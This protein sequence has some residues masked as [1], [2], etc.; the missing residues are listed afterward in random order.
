GYS[1]VQEFD[2]KEQLEI[3]K[4][5]RGFLRMYTFLIQATAYQNEVLHERYNYIQA[6][7]KEID[8]TL[9]GTDFTIADK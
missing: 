9:G 2:E 1:R 6:L 4:V 8:V 3:K 7:V 5:F